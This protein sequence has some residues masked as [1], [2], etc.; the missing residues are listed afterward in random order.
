MIDGRT[1]KAV[2]SAAAYYQNSSL[3][4]VCSMCGKEFRKER[5]ICGTMVFLMAGWD[6]NFASGIIRCP[7]CIPRRGKL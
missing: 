3:R 2:R 1:R 6:L 5:V 4:A 7:N